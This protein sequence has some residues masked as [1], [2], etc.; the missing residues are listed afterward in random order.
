MILTNLPRRLVLFLPALLLLHASTVRCGA[1]DAPQVSLVADA[2]MGAPARHGLR[3]LEAALREKGYS[4]ETVNSLEA[5][6]G[7][8][9]IVA[10]LTGRASTAAQLL[11][12]DN[13]VAP[14]GAE[15][16]VI[17]RSQWKGRS[18]VVLAGSN[19][20]GLMYA[21]L[22]TADRIGW[23]A[24]RENPLAEIRETVETPGVSERALSVYTMNR[25]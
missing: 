7:K 23:S 10:G 22:D 3:K 15:A 17:H 25:R 5:A 8:T 11:K 2:S 1:A 21:E 16:L 20:R 4:L 14:S 19:D 12:D 18:A 13:L 6:R 9:L 24:D